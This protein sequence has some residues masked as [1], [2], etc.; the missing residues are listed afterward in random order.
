MLHVVLANVNIN[1]WNNSNGIILELF[2]ALQRLVRTSQKIPCRKMLHNCYFKNIRH[3][4]PSV[5]TSNDT[6]DVCLYL[7]MEKQQNLSCFISMLM[8]LEI[9]QRLRT[10]VYC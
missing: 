1:L 2:H 9:E 4:C 6:K 3:C 10:A 7:H 5:V 8:Y